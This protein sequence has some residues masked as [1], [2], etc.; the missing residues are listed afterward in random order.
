PIGKKI[1]QVSA[2]DRDGEGPNN[3]VTF[4]VNGKGAERFQITPDTGIISLHSSLVPDQITADRKYEILVEAKDSGVPSLTSSVTVT[5]TAYPNNK[6][7]VFVPK[8]EY[9]VTIPEDTK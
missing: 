4:L 9:D 3:K 2:T 6:L 5:I 1:V 8:D 7:P